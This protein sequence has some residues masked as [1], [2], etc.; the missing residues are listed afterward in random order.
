MP[1][2]LNVSVSLVEQVL[3]RGNPSTVRAET[4]NIHSLVDSLSLLPFEVQ[5]I[6]FSYSNGSILWRLAFVLVFGKNLINLTDTKA[7]VKPLPPHQWIRGMS[8]TKSLRC[9]SIGEVVRIGLDGPGIKTCQM[10]KDTST[11]DNV[12]CEWYIIGRASS[13]QD[14]GLESLVSKILIYIDAFYT[15]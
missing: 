9:E 6:I 1:L 4:T 7:I 15:Y 10:L 12:T 2:P 5:C 14:I 8:L 11:R 13:S 3:S